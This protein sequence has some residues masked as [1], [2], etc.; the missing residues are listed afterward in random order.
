MNNMQIVESLREA[1][2]VK[3]LHTVQTINGNTVSQHVYGGLI[4]LMDLVKRSPN[5]VLTPDMMQEFI[6]HDVPELETGDIPAPTKRTIGLELHEMETQIM[7]EHGIQP[8][9]LSEEEKKL[10]KCADYLDLGFFCLHEVRMGNRHPRI[11]MVFANIVKYLKPFEEQV[12][13]IPEYLEYLQRE[14]VHGIVR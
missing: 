13:G 5:V 4:I 7:A 1:G 3:R 9:V 6:F 12:A 2:M 8:K 11:K 14:F 10:I